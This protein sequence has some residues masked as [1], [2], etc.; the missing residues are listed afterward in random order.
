MVERPVRLF[1]DIALQIRG[2]V[3]DCRGQLQYAD[4]SHDKRTGL[5]IAIHK[6]EMA[7]QLLEAN[8]SQAN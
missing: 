1:C 4:L 2:L 8:A 5:Q 3:A 6:L 7:A